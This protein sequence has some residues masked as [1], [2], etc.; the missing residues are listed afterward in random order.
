MNN[1]T[2]L[3]C[4]GVAGIVVVI[5]VASIAG[6]YSIPFAIAAVGA[7]MMLMGSH[8]GVYALPTETATLLKKGIKFALIAIVT[9]WG[10]SLVANAKKAEESKPATPTSVKKT[11]VV[12]ESGKNAWDL[13]QRRDEFINESRELTPGVSTTITFPCYRVKGGVMWYQVST[14]PRVE[15]EY[16]FLD[17]EPCR[18]DGPKELLVVKRWPPVMKI[19]SIGKGGK[20][21]IT[22]NRQFLPDPPKKEV[23]KVSFRKVRTAHKDLVGEDI[24]KAQQIM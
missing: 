21:E 11:Q 7:A 23:K 15:V 1:Q 17:G 19:K 24:P 16:D 18:K 12:D 8:L 6:F 9:V 4:A 14:A 3:I 2:R 22:L 10:V 13:S 20:M 5:L